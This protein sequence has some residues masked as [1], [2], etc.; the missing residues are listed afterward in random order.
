MV[1]RSLNIFLLLPEG[2]WPLE[3]DR[4]ESVPQFASLIKY[5]ILDNYPL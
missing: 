4:S 3:G 5:A 2:S 1:E